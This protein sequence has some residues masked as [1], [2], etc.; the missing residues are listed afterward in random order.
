MVAL[1]CEPGLFLA[2]CGFCA[3]LQGGCLRTEPILLAQISFEDLSRAGLRQALVKFHRTR[4]LVMS[5]AL[6]AVLDEFDLTGALP[7]L[8]DDQCF[9]HFAP[10]F[11]ED[12]NDRR[13]QD[14]GVRE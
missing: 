5:E 9:W 12:G 6:A 1:L 7:R 14:R 11:V 4:A 2:R 10:N 13:F 3:G 8:Q